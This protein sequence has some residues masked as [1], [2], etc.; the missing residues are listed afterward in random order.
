[1]KDVAEYLGDTPAV[2]RS[3]Y[4]DPRVVDLYMDGV[5]VDP[6]LPGNLPPAEIADSTAWPR[7]EAAVLDLLDERGERS[8]A[9]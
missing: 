3:S 2:A 9:A 6:A 4:V 8:Q 1:M 5:T 7:L